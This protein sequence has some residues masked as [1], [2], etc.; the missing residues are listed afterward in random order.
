MNDRGGRAAQPQILGRAR[1]LTAVRR[2]LAGD[3]A[4]HRALLIRGEPGLGKTTLWSAALQAS[5]AQGAIVAVSRPSSAESR[6]AHLVLSDLLD[7]LLGS[8]PATLAGLSDQQRQ[9]LDDVVAGAAPSSGRTWRGVAAAFL[10]ALRAAATSAPVVLAVDDVQWMDDSS[11]R[12]LDYVLARCDDADVR[13]VATERVELTG[14]PDGADPRLERLAPTYLDLGALAPDDITRLLRRL[15]PLPPEV[16]ASAVTDSACNPFF[17][18]ELARTASVPTTPRSRGPLPRSLRGI[19]AYRLRGLS[20]TCLQA[21]RLTCLLGRPTTDQLHRLLG[22]AAADAGL[23]EAQAAG[24]L[25]QR[26]GLW[27][28]RHPLLASAVYDGLSPLDRRYLHR[29]AAGV[30]GDPEERA[31]HLVES[32]STTDD[33]IAAEVTR[34]AQSVVERGAP[35]NALALLRAAIA[36]ERG[37]SADAR[38]GRRL[39]AALALL[40][41]DRPAEA[42]DLAEE[43]VE[44][45]QDPTRRARALQAAATA[46]MELTGP[47]DAVDL[48]ERAVLLPA[49][50]VTMVGIVDDLVTVLHSVDRRA[51]ATAWCI[52]NARRA[53]ELGDA[54]L[55]AETRARRWW[56]AFQSD[57]VT[58]AEALE[59]AI[60][61]QPRGVRVEILTATA[62]VYADRPELAFTAWDVIHERATLRGDALLAAEFA[63]YR[64]DLDLRVGNTERATESLRHRWQHASQDQIRAAYEHAQA[65]FLRAIEG[66]LDRGREEAARAVVLG[67]DYPWL[68]ARGHASLGFLELTADDPLAAAR[69]LVRATEADTDLLESR[70]GACWVGVDLVE[71]L[72]SSGRADEAQHAL[73]RLQRQSDTWGDGWICAAVQRSRAH[74]LLCTGQAGAALEHAESAAAAYD[75]LPYPLDRGRSLLLVGVLRRRL[76]RRRDARGALSTAVESFEAAGSPPWQ[77]RAL[78]ELGRLGGRPP[79]DGALTP[80]EL[81]IADKVA[82]GM[83]NAEIATALHVSV[84]TVESHLTSIYRKL[85]VGSRTQLVRALAEREASDANLSTT[86]RV[87]HRSV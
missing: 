75:A 34:A 38:A 22:P 33:A 64:T 48:L 59:A 63:T 62:A 7:D 76:G 84:R 14:D 44:L 36:L 21:C 20:G 47:S 72:A 68:Q 31:W 69:A 82:A 45:G 27:V 26:D 66:E 74:V 10:A 70:H 11:A 86:D 80:S 49:D 40:A 39:D 16:V 67:A 13:L 51:E 8:G 60:T 85:Q 56:D 37:G 24:I 15:G 19:T 6:L 58:A 41:L 83:S 81:P 53:R 46:A 78:D 57:R 23:D 52:D 12:A 17:A 2:W 55:V 77:A 50:P 5:S 32:T 3:A 35:D 25:E 4:R 87:T 28:F 71:A 61:L 30:V 1:E 43:A 54:D 73:D 65:A 79:S 18:L 29:Q 9:L 42:R